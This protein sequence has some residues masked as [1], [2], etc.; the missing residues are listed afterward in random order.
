MQSAGRADILTA[1]LREF[2]DH[3]FMGATTAGIA[4]RAG[5]TQ[6]LVH[7][8]FG[9]KQGLWNAVLADVFGDLDSVLGRTIQEVEGEDRRTRLARLLRALVGFF[10]RRPELSRL[11]RTESSA[12]GAPF[13]ELYTRW[14]SGMV[15]LFRR[16]VSAAVEDGALRPV[17]P[18]LAYSFIIG[19][20]AQ[21]FAEPETV[22]RAFGLDMRDPATVERYAEFAVDVL[23][24]GLGL[25]PEPSRPARKRRR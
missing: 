7:H 10:G 11:I 21:P 22:R 24:R 20:C 3:G 9:S 16:E 5:V 25:P 2:A 4:R 17:D 18:R 14:L 12:G 19:A 6:P 15:D 13:D 23:L 1:A 8:H